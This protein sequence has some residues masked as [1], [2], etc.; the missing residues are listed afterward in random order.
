[1]T[2]NV[3]PNSA[4]GRVIHDAIGISL[5][6][7]TGLHKY[8]LEALDRLL[9]DIMD[10]PEKPFGGKLLLMSGDWQQGLPVI[11]GGSRAQIVDACIRRSVLWDHVEVLEL[12]ENMRVLW[13][14][15]EDQEKLQKWNEM[16]QKMGK[17]EGI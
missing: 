1:M 11:P 9:R 7:A 5:D 12:E 6:E 8:Y 2:F 10:E 16:L 14:V 15:G 17:G 4:L 3:P 13:H